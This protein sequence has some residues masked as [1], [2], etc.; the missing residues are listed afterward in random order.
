MLMGIL[1]HFYS[2]FEGF[3]SKKEHYLLCFQIF[4]SKDLYDSNDHNSMSITPY[5]CK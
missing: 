5:R 2:V 1:L 3:K 4:K